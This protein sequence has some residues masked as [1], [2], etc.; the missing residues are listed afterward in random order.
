MELGAALEA[1]ASKKWPALGRP[2]KVVD[3][4]AV[5]LPDSDANQRAYPQ[6]SG[7]KPGCGFPVMYLCALMGLASGAILDVATGTA[8]KEHPLFRR[9]W[10]SVREGDILLADAG[11]CSYAEIALLLQ[12]GV[13]CLVR[14]CRRKLDPRH[15][16]RIGKGDWLTQWQRPR[17]PGKWVLPS[18]LPQSLVMRIVRFRVQVKGFRSR[19]VTLATTLL[20]AKRY[21]K[22]QLVKLYRR[23]W[24]MEL[25]LRDI[26]TTMGL[27]V[28]RCKSP[29]GSRKE[30]WMGLIA[31]NMIRTVMIDAARRGRLIPARISFAGTVQ[32]LA[33]VA[34][35]RLMEQSPQVAYCVLLDHLAQDRLPRRANRVEPRKIKLRP[36]QYSRLTEPRTVWKQKALAA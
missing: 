31:Y 1:E 36:K 18:Q 25:R 10:R 3:G 29:C 28:L 9:L 30:L 24:E 12:A 14:L 21:P 6:P 35:G 8:G 22:R 11:L 4:T 19:E 7:Q 27:E 34:C 13:D 26:K 15:A 33:E 20:D 23:R 32:R 16:R 2:V 5:R 17:E